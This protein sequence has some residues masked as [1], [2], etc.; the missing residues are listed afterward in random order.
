M[1][2]AYTSEYLLIDARDAVSGK[3]YFCPVCD[4]KLNFYPGK[5]ISAHFKHARGVPKEQ[6]EQC[7]LYTITNAYSLLQEEIFARQRIRIVIENEKDNFVFKMKFPLIRSHLLDMQINDKYFNYFCN[8]LN[9]FLL[10]S[11]HLLPSRSNND[12]KVP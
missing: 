1:D 5:K 7:E 6:K 12:V 3:K 10:N 8:E 2:R 4:G 11:I 9:D